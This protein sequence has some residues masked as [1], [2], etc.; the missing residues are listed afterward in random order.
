[1]GQCTMVILSKDSVTY[2]IIITTLNFLS[3]T[4]KTYPASS[5]A[6]P[7]TISYKSQ[8]LTQTSTL[9][10]LHHLQQDTHNNK[11]LSPRYQ[12]HMYTQHIKKR[13]FTWIY[14]VFCG[15]AGHLVS[16][17]SQSVRDVPTSGR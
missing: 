4:P 12:K 3:L 15:P 8:Q 6:Q 16:A 14:C 7:R 9:A 10:W 13:R 5:R 2:N 17:V 11:T 1:M